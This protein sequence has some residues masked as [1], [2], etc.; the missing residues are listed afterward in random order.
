MLVAVELVA[1]LVLTLVPSPAAP[2]QPEQASCATPGARV[3][4][5]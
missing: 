1:A 4:A 3:E 5:G 2:T